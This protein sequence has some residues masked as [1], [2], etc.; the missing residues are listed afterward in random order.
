MKFLRHVNT[1]TTSL[2]LGLVLFFA[3]AGMVSLTAIT[4]CSSIDKIDTNTA[5]GGVKLADEY[6][7]DERYEEAIQKY[8]EVKNKFP[9]SKLA[10][11]SELKIADIN[12]KRESFIEAQNNYQLFKEFHPKNPQSDYVTFRLGMSYFKQL[13]STID[14]DLSLAEKAIVYFDEVMSSFPQST[15]VTE[16]KERKAQSLHMLAGKEMYIAGFYDKKKMYDSAMKRYEGVLKSYPN[17]GYDAQALY[18]AAKGAFNTGEKD[19]A[20]QHLKNLYSLFPTSSEAQRAK[21]EFEK[22]GTN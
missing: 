1:L 5:E 6:A 8:T 3:T 10:T 17:A 9:Y 20:S 21:N 7:K 11:E 16:S 19:R 18:G 2:S 14:R 15:Y 12:Y 4:G 13:P 22:L